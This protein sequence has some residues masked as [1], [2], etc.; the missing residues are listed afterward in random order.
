MLSHLNDN[1]NLNVVIL[2]AIMTFIRFIS[3]NLEGL[4]VCFYL[5]NSITTQFPFPSQTKYVYHDIS[6]PK[7]LLY[8]LSFHY[9]LPQA[10]DVVK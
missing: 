9:S 2:K 8:A 7:I 1:L 3:H 5:V 10:P 6:A 4:R